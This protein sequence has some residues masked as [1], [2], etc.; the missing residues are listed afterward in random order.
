MVEKILFGPIELLPSAL[1]DGAVL[2]IE[3]VTIAEYPYTTYVFLDEI[4]SENIEALI[5]TQR[6]AGCFSIV[7]GSSKS[8]RIVSR[9]VK[10]ECSCMA[11]TDNNNLSSCM[12]LK[13]I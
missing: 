6:Y 12:R 5:R 10:A 1:V 8:L 4:H 9:F 11:E 7:S 3:G 2:E 13:Y